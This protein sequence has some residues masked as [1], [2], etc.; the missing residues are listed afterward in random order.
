MTR[1]IDTPACL[2]HPGRV[3]DRRVGR[4]A[5]ALALV[6]LAAPG[7]GGDDASPGEL[8]VDATFNSLGVLWQVGG[9]DDGDS[10]CLLEFRRVDE[11]TW[12]PGAPAVRARAG[13][14]VGGEPLAASYW[15]A[16]AMFLES[17]ASYEL[18]LTLTDPDGGGA[19][20]TATAATRS[21]PQPSPAGRRLHAV[22][23]SGGGSGSAEDPFRGLQS[24]AD[25]VAPGD[26][27]SV[28]P[29]R[30]APFELAASGAEGLPIAFLGS[31]LGTEIV[32]GAGTERG[33]VTLSSGGSDPIAHVIVEGLTIENGRWGVDVQHGQSVTI[34]RNHI[35][36]VDYGVV[37]RREDG[38][39]RD[40][41]VC[42]NVIEGRTGWPGTGIPSERGIDLRGTGN[43][44][45][46]NRVRSF[47]DC[48]SVQ[49][50]SGP[51][52]G[53]DVF[54]NDLAFCVDDG[55]EV[56]F[57]Q[58]NVR[59]WR[60]RVYNAR[61]GVSLQPIRGGPAYV[62]RNELFNL[63]SSPLKLNNSPSG[64]IVVHN[65]GVKLGAGVR[66]ADDSTWRNALFRNNLFLGT[67]YAFEFSSV[68]DDGSR[69]LDYGA[70]G[71]TRAG[72][73]GEPHFKWDNQRYER[74]DDLRDATGREAHG[75][76]AVFGDLANPAPPASWDVAVEPAGRDLRL[77]PGAPE[78][79]AGAPLPN[80]NDAFAVD[81]DPDL[82]AFELGHPLPHYGPRP[83][84][85][86]P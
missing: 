28:A 33:V 10:A 35:R 60:N 78:V 75:V 11:P 13:V 17:G 70:W 8:R 16:S 52:Y 55:I 34:R 76:S 63:E 9:D 50:M 68:S 14:L 18:R 74:L 82:G 21:E 42:D 67:G 25:G 29:G 37:N 38:R 41:T 72:T 71:T 53:N 40:Q 84:A 59:V 58:S 56:D 73:A 5:L 79:D 39:E 61:M 66:D 77:V 86:V 57:N 12:R 2:R 48:V 23:G 32:D 31:G 85:A 6:C 80:L 46:H 81:G 27:V 15:A 20:L 49:P 65:T 19:T 7:R 51:S 64:L 62:V 83:P 45:C 44:V 3:R 1:R 4:G 24:A 26:V 36:A 30:Y 22:P 47:G 54:G 69:D 43:V